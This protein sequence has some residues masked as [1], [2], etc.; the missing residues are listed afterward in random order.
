MMEIIK[1]E[2]NKERD[3]KAEIE[4]L[5]LGWKVLIVWQCEI[6][7]DRQLE[8]RIIDFMQ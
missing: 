8:T 2:R 3:K 4:L 1:I 6:E 5:Q 7:K